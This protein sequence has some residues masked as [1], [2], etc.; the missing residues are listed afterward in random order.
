MLFM[1]LS[2]FKK[3]NMEN[4]IDKRSDDSGT[5]DK[6]VS[7]LILCKNNTEKIEE[8]IRRLGF[9]PETFA[10]EP[11]D[12]ENMFTKP[13]IAKAVKYAKEHEYHLVFTVDPDSNRFTVAVRIEPEGKFR[14]LNVHQL[15]VLVTDLLIKSFSENTGVILKSFRI[16]E[17]LNKIASKNSIKCIDYHQGQLSEAIINLEKENKKVLLM[18]DENLE[19]NTYE[20]DSLYKIISLLVEREAMLRRSNKTLFDDLIRLFVENGFYKEKVLAINLQQKTQSKHY[21]KILDLMRKG[22]P[23]TLLSGEVKSVTDYKKGTSKNFLSGKVTKIS[24]PPLNAVNVILSDGSSIG[25]ELGDEKM[26]YHISV[27]S[28]IHSKDQFEEVNK[29]SKKRVLKLI[30]SLNRLS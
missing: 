18:V 23:D 17:M 11:A 19:F 9:I 30:E 12:E 22:A 10:I 27:R 8:S 14:I 2:S 21:N 25:M 6:P 3:I 28:K 13:V 15:A 26:T 16:T 24:S 4:T 20:E 29:S 1:F 7:V 5:Q